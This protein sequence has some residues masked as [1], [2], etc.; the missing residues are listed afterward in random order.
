MTNNDT[1]AL[2]GDP[3]TD[4]SDRERAGD[5]YE[6]DSGGLDTEQLSRDL[7]AV[8]WDLKALN[9]VAIDLRGRVS[10]TDFVIVCTGQSERHVRALSKNVEQEMREAGWEPLSAEGVESGHWAVLDFAD[11]VVH[12]FEGRQRDEYDLEG[13]WVDADRLEFDDPPEDLYG[14]FQADRFE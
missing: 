5:V 1:V 7:V 3:S 2:D 6:V 9:A 8:L 13:M 4:A 10:Y 11:V 12:V 14:H